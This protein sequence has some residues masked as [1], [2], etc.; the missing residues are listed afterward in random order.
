MA[1]FEAGAP[2]SEH[3]TLP[4]RHRALHQAAGAI[5]RR[6]RCR[7]SWTKKLHVQQRRRRMKMAFCPAKAYLTSRARQQKR[8]LM[9][10]SSQVKVQHQGTQCL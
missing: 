8:Q 4:Y 5:Q 6:M 9:A 10:A 3:A 1:N 7:W 2:A